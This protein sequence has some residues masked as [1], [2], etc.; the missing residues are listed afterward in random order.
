MALESE[1][2]LIFD[3]PTENNVSSFILVWDPITKELQYID[4]SNVNE[5]LQSVIDVGSTAVTVSAIQLTSND[6]TDVSTLLLSNDS[7]ALTRNGIGLSIESTGVE[8]NSTVK[9]FDAIQNNEFVTKQQ[10]DNASPP[11]L[12][13]VMNSGSD[14]TVSTDVII[15]SING[16]NQGL[17]SLSVTGTVNLESSNKLTL[18]GENTIVTI[19][20]SDGLT[21]TAGGGQINI[22]TDNV[23]QTRTL[24]APDASGTIALEENQN[25]QTI[26]DNGNVTTNNVTVGEE[27]NVGAN[28]FGVININESSIEYDLGQLSLNSPNKIQIDVFTGGRIE[29]SD[30]EGFSIMPPQ[31]PKNLFLKNTNLTDN[32]NYEFPNASGTLSLQPSTAGFCYFDGTN[33][34]ALSGTASEY[35][36]ADGTIGGFSFQ[37]RNSQI[38]TNTGVNE[39]LQNNFSI[40]DAVWT[41]NNRINSILENFIFVNDATYFPDAVSNIITLEANKTYYITTH[42]DLNG[43]RLVAGENT[44]ILGSSSE[45]SSLT[46]TGL[47]AGVPLLTSV[48]TCPIRYI[49]FK[50]VDTA[51]D[52]DGLGNNMALDWVGVNFL[53]VPNVGTIK[54]ANNF[55]YSTG[56]FL[57]SQGL[58][59]DGTFGTIGLDSSLFSGSGALGNILSIESTCIIQRRFRIDRSAVVANTDTTGIN[60][61]IAAVVPDE[62][63]ILDT[64]NF[65]GNGTFLNGVDEEDNKSLFTNCTGIDN[66]F[67]GF[68]MYAEDQSTETIITTSGQYEKAIITTTEGDFIGRFTHSNNKA[69]YIGSKTR[70]FIIESCLSVLTTTNFNT[71]AVK[72]YKNGSPVNGSRTQ[73]TTSRTGGAD[74]ATNITSIAVV[75]LATNDYIE[76]YVTNLSSTSNLVATD[77]S[78]IIN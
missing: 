63:Y 59:F 24:Q 27:L 44:V 10:L 3:Q 45:N 21:L 54:D 4:K 40:Q 71:V 28:D 43:D 23:T 37:A 72:I 19:D 57:N 36:K 66:T 46:S 1:K 65:G 48:Y 56:A 14:A 58:I 51:L 16:A 50:D 18:R 74:A 76:V 77:L 9:G 55:I 73:G 30:V 26:T 2:I 17:L 41:N 68:S 49:T 13:T 8:F 5:D 22:K 61:D 6:G 11:N 42:V 34:S 69:T 31:T 15:E 25:L 33:T 7:A 62:S 67:E 38:S 29:L 52:F 53:N 32:R 78:L 39:P 47:A 12:Q 20:N 35:L 64:V 70:T 60:F 75:Q